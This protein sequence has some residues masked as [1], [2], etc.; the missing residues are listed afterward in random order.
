MLLANSLDDV[1]ASNDIATWVAFN[2]EHMNEQVLQTIRVLDR[3]FEPT[4][5]ICL[6]LHA[7]KLFFA[8]SDAERLG[9]IHVCRYRVQAEWLDMFKEHERKHSSQIVFAEYSQL[10][11]ELEFSRHSSLVRDKPIQEWS[12]TIKAAKDAEHIKSNN[13]DQILRCL[14]DQD[15]GIPLD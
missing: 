5:D 6:Q 4:D 13:D 8:T 15:K 9:G 7:S 10:F 3:N 14:Y 12:A 1:F 11:G 2:Y